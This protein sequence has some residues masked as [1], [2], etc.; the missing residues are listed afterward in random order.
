MRCYFSTI[1]RY[2]CT[3]VIKAATNIPSWTKNVSAWAVHT[4]TRMS[5]LRD[6]ARANGSYSLTFMSIRPTSGYCLLF[7]VAT[8]L[9]HGNGEVLGVAG[10]VRRVGQTSEQVEANR[11]SVGSVV[12]SAKGSVCRVSCPPTEDHPGRI[13]L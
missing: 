8:H 6:T 1:V 5:S 4:L 13:W 7:D 2:D 11:A 12:L 10:L 3:T 9:V